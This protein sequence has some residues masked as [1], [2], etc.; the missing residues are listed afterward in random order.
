M[1]LV[2]ETGISNLYAAS[3]DGTLGILAPGN[4]VVV[5]LQPP[6]ACFCLS[7]NSTGPDFQVFIQGGFALRLPAT[8]QTL[9]VIEHG[10][11]LFSP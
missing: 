2:T 8:R 1:T 3:P 10:H 7:E 9:P 5:A 11:S 6:S 4:A